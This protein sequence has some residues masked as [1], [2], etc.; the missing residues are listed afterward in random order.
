MTG[1]D[2]GGMVVVLTS[3]SLLYLAP[4]FVAYS[5]A[6]PGFAALFSGMLYEGIGF[7]A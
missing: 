7:V 5:C 2:P 4:F 6:F 1:Y 3:R